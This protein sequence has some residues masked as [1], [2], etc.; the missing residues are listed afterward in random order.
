LFADG[1]QAYQFFEMGRSSKKMV[2]MKLK[3]MSGEHCSFGY[4]VEKGWTITERG[5]EKMSA[6]GTFL[7]M[8]SKT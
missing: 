3:A 1:P 4:N 5:K 6:N 2:Q 7:F 8:K